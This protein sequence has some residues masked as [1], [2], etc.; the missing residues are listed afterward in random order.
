MLNLRD[1]NY[2]SLYDDKVTKEYAIEITRLKQGEKISLLSDTMLKTMFQND[3]RLKYSCKFLSYFLD[4]SFESLMENIKLSKNELDKNNDLDKGERCDYVANINDTSIN[5]EVNNNSGVEVMERN[6]EYAH[7]LYAKKI[8]RGIN[9]NYRYTQVIQFNLNNF[10]FVGNDKIVDIYTVQNNEGIRLNN[11]LIFV[12]IYV[13]NLRKKWYNYGI[14]SL[15]EE[16]KYLLALVEKDLSKLKELG[17]DI[18]MKE[19]I[20]EA[21]EVSYDEKVG[22]SYDKEWALK[23]EGRR[24]SREEIAISMIKRN[25]D[26]TLISEITGFSEEEI[27]KLQD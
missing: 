10:A 5:I 19:Y 17:D 15:K 1:D 3:N 16:E 18:I 6:M 4:I 2:K 22:E 25:M 23:D 27:N 7:R 24:E 13:P 9:K 8:K 26:I 11:K 12:Q 14:E 20:E 21:E